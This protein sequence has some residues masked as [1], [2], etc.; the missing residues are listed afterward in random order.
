MQKVSQSNEHSVEIET[1]FENEKISF[2]QIR[3]VFIAL[4]LNMLDGF[5]I[6]AMA[7]TAHSIGETFGLLPEQLGLIFSVTLAGMMLGAMLLSPLA[8]IV[9]RRKVLLI[10]VAL[11]ASTMILFGFCT[12]LWQMVLLRFITGL[13][14]GSM[15][16]SLAAL[17][18]EYTPSKYR[19]FT[20]AI[21]TAGYPLGATLGGFITAPLLPIYGWQNI[22]IVGGLMTF[23]MLFAVTLWMPESLQFLAARRPKKA[24]E[25]IN[26]IMAKLYKPA[27]ADL[28]PH[29]QDKVVP[30]ASVF[31]LINDEFRNKTLLLWTTFFFCFICLYFLMSWIP[32]LV[33]NSG[34]S[35]AQGVYAAVAL[36][37]G[38]V[39]GIIL[40]GWLAARISL[41][42]LIGTFLCSAAISMIVLATF[43]PHLPLLIVLMVIGFLLQGGFVGL[44]SVAAKIYPTEIRTT[45]VGWAIGLGRF[46][47]VVGPYVGGVLIAN[48]YSMELNFYIFAIPLIISG[49]F[50]YKLGVK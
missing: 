38:G 26:T 23:V 17:T 3:V 14:V 30:K 6:S 13:G 43:L 29:H 16:A 4:I 50:A 7:F 5:D 32:K 39:V 11:I 48:G 49:L 36:N 24:L 20:I 47:A 46:G 28:P 18:S 31:S 1:I 44:Y 9:G 8:D 27:L 12:S 10:C 41:S 37:G 33:I 35:E 2:L 19:S 40:L 21:I 34:L 22:F 42:T 25:K 45:G 15:L